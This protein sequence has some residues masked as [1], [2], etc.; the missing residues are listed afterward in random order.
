[1]RNKVIFNDGTATF[2]DSFSLILYRLSNWL[3]S[4]DKFFIT[5]GTSLIMGPEGI[6]DWS[7]TK[8]RL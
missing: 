1:M 7:N 6:I 2:K 5:T 8:L 3:K 4:A